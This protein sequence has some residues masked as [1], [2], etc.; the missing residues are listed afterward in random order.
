MQNKHILLKNDTSLLFP[1]T[2]GSFSSC[3]PYVASF[4]GLSIFDCSCGIFYRLFTCNYYVIEII[5][6]NIFLYKTILGSMSNK[7]SFNISKG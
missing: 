7:K 4:S 5:I 2:P 1:M 6:L 3:V